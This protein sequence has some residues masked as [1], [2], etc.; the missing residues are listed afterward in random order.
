MNPST[1]EKVKCPNS[2]YVVHITQ[3]QICEESLEENKDF[4][5]NSFY[6]YQNKKIKRKKKEKE[7]G[8]LPFTI[9]EFS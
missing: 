5:N 9:P 2:R 3:Y 1:F 4:C 6:N 8:G 7:Q